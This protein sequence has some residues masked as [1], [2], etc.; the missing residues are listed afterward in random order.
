MHDM[1]IHGDFQT[2]FQHFF[3]PKKQN[4]KRPH[5][6]EVNLAVRFLYF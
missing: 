2:S 4:K 6:A 3:A 1:Q 5:I